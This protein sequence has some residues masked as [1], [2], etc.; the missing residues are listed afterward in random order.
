VD[1]DPRFVLTTLQF[2]KISSHADYARGR[3]LARL[4]GGARTLMSS[5]RRCVCGVV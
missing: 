5:Y 3:R 2:A 4:N 1:C